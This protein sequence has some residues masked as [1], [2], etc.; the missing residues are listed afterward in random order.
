MTT[1]PRALAFYRYHGVQ[2]SMPW[3]VSN[4][5]MYYNPVAFQKAGLNP[6]SPPQTFAQVTAA[7]KKI[8]AAHAATHGVALPAKPYVFEFLLAKSGG[9][10]VNNGNGRIARATAGRPDQPDVHEGLAVVEPD[11]HLAPGAWL[12]ARIPTTSTI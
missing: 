3:A 4:V 5:I 2:Q 7:S 9:Q 6:N 10:Y 1:W 8:V 11:A 12:R